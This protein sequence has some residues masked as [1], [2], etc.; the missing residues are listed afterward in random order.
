MSFECLWMSLC[1]V[2]IAVPPRWRIE[3]I[4]TSVVKGRNAVIDCDTDAYPPPTISWS[5][6]EGEPSYCDQS[7]HSGSWYPLYSD[8]IAKRFASKWKNLKNDNNNYKIVGKVWPVFEPNREPKEAYYAVLRHKNEIPISIG[9]KNERIRDALTRLHS[10]Y[11][12]I[13]I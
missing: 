6:A 2:A 1:S 10:M 5:R 11:S 8:N 12:L 7:R 13:T 4:D 3:P 9:T